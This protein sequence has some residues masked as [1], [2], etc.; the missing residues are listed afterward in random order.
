M[1]SDAGP[2]ELGIAAGIP[3]LVAGIEAEGA[4]VEGA[5]LGHYQSTI[6]MTNNEGGAMATLITL[7][8]IVAVIGAIAKG[9]A[10]KKGGDGASYYK[11]KPLTQQ[12][13]VLY[14]RLVKALPGHRVL[15][16]VS[17]SALIGIKKGKDWQRAFNQTSRK[18]ADFV[19]CSPAFEVLAIIELDDKSHDTE[20]GQKADRT[21]DSALQSA[22]HRVI[23]WRQKD[24]PPVEEIAHLFEAAHVSPAS[25]P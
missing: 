13:Q 20:K 15:A 5:H 25:L 7:I 11:K 23:R 22:G 10:A 6:V 24:I 4:T 3:V 19:I 21:K 17:L 2:D 18:Y 8:I 1:A 9:V 16:Q 12:E 14:Y